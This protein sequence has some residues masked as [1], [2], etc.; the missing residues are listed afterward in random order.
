MYAGAMRWL[1]LVFF[2][3]GCSLMFVHGPPA[4]HEKAESFDCT[5]SWGTVVADAT[6]ASVFGL[7]TLGM[8]APR[9]PG[10][11]KPPAAAAAMVGTA[12]AIFT[13]SA[14]Y[15]A[16]NGRQCAAAKRDLGE[17]VR[18]QAERNK[19]L[20]ALRK[21]HELQTQRRHA[22]CTRD[23]DCKGA[24]ICV[25]SQC[26]DPPPVVVPSALTSPA[27]PSSEPPT[28]ASPPTAPSAPPE[29]AS[30]VP[31]GTAPPAPTSPP[32]FPESPR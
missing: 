12:A 16:Y 21:E 15:G 32:T 31:S 18:Q 4:G 26:I 30:A 11:E 19:V 1:P 22:G 24:R 28:Q 13:A 6:G 17:R 9:E 14:I 2:L 7:T 23:I 5:S 27:P 8:T 25:A 3:P 29:G 20:E 10:E